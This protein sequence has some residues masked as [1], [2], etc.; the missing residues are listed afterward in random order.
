[1]GLAIAGTL[2]AT[3]ILAASAQRRQLRRA[4][5]KQQAVEL[6]DRFLTAWARDKFDASRI[7]EAAQL[8]SVSLRGF[9]GNATSG[10]AKNIDLSVRHMAT[11]RDFAIEVIRIEA[12]VDK[13]E[14]P[15]CW[16]E[17]VRSN[18]EASP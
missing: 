2:L 7:I 16:I 4:D 14:T 17:V 15:I 9:Q 6:V 12:F 13:T 10:A 1:M 8:S 5:S 11:Y 18:K 3:T